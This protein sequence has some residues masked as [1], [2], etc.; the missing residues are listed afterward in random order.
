MATIKEH[1]S[2]DE[3]EARYKRAADP[4]AKSHFHA[5]WL[6][7]LGRTIGE[8]AKLLSFSTRWVGL[9]I[10]RYN[11]GGPEAL[12]DRRTGNGAAPRIL[13]ERIRTPP[14]DGGLWSGPKVARWLACLHGLKSVH[15]QRGWDALIAIDYS[16][17]RPRPRHPEAADEADRA[18]LKK[19]LRRR[20]PKS[21]A[22]IPT[23][24]SNS[25]RW[26]N[27]ASA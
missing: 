3:L 24:K 8:V 5:V 13:T 7:S 16:I 20:P 2:S 21:R 6:L 12:G 18:A 1:L 23:P 22:S 4:I 9:L 27:I 14:D 10:K 11:E 17:Q 26:T 25:G 19:S 15:D